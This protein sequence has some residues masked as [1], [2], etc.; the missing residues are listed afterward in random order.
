ML[1]FE[2]LFNSWVLRK[3]EISIF[4]LVTLGFQD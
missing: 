1:G 4:I 2:I 3:V